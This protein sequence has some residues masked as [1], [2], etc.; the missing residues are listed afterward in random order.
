MMWSLFVLDRDGLV[1][2]FEDEP[3]D[4]IIRQANHELETFVL[5]DPEIPQPIDYESDPRSILSRHIDEDAYFSCPE[6]VA[7]QSVVPIAIASGRLFFAIDD[8]DSLS[9]LRAWGFRG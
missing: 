1:H 6:N 7:M 2:L 4:E 8:D 9:L 5:S 3:F